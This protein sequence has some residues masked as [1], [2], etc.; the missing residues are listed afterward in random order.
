MY[1]PRSNKP[2]SLWSYHLG[3]NPPDEYERR[4]L[5]LHAFV[6]EDTCY[7]VANS[8]W[9]VN[10]MS[11][12]LEQP[13]RPP[14][15]TQGGPIYLPAHHHCLHIAQLFVQ[16]VEISEHTTLEE[17][18][19]KITSIRQLWEVLHRRL[20]GYILAN[21][22]ILQEPHDY[23]GG[24]LCRNSEWE[25]SNDTVYGEVRIYLHICYLWAFC[26]TL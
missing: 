9:V 13:P 23:F 17:Y 26:L 19:S 14:P 12:K 11:V 16:N 15:L 4:I 24:G 3:L 8:D 10:A 1:Y 7:K 5:L 21:Q 20:D 6:Q 25:P 18:R 2:R 22:Y